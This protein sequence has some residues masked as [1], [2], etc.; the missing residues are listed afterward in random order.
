M[1]GKGIIFDFGGYSIKIGV[2]IVCMKLDMVGV[3]VVL[4]IVKVMVFVKVDINVV[5]V[6]GMVVN[7][8][9]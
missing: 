7:M 8:V 5:V 1:I 4:G 9:L 3:V 2:L 6:M